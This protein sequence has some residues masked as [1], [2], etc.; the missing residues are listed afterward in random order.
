M[1]TEQKPL[2]SGYGP[3]TT[4]EEVLRGIDL[5]GR[6]A[7]VT[8]G[9][10]GLGLETVRVL[11]QAGAQ[12]WVPA[13]DV[14]RAQAALKVLGAAVEPMDLMD[15]ASID[16]FAD[17]FLSSGKPLAILINSAG[18]MAC[19]LARD[20][21]G[22]ESQFSTN[23]LGHFQL[24]LRLW[25]ALQKAQGA[26]V[27]TLSSWG[28]RHSPVHLEDPNFERREYTPWLGY[29][30]SKTANV[31]FAL[32]LDRRGQTEGIRAFS[33]HPGGIV[34]TGLGKHIT[35]EQ[36]RAGGAIDEKGQPVID[37]ERG[38]KT[39]AQGAATGVWC[40]TSPQLKGIGGVY[41]Q[42]CDVAPL[43]DLTG[44]AA[45]KFASKPLGVMPYAVDPKIAEELWVLSEKL[46]GVRW[47]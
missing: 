24:T 17:H 32:E 5:T 26:R 11:R 4:A 27:V 29:G 7:I 20:R 21:R 43:V 44:E 16:A 38:L 30:Q 8:G 28:H 47:P 22:Y 45:K 39:V 10:S 19:P 3:S 40:A 31:L 23:H 14:P 46:T 37:P 25:P 15:P 35:R 12:V 33:V 18:I 36:L 6:S 9:Y 34:E 13:R 1:T 2:H 42:D 41:C